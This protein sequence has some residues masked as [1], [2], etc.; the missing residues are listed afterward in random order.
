M[1]CTADERQSPRRCA[2]AM[3]G[4]VALMAALVPAALAS[5]A[6]A[7]EEAVQREHEALRREMRRLCGEKRTGRQASAVI[8]QHALRKRRR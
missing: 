2:A 1:P 4:A 5:N 3:R 8:R 6:L 7:D